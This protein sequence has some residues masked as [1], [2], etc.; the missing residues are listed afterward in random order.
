MRY[1]TF[2]II[3]IIILILASI[4]FYKPSLLEGFTGSQTNCPNILIQKDAKF[5]LYNT[6]IDE[7]PGVN[8]IVFDNLEQY[9]EF[10]D[11]QSKN[12]I[13]CPVLFLQKSYNTQ[14]AT[15]YKMRPS[16]TEPQ[17]GLPPIGA[18]TITKANDQRL[19]IPVTEYDIYD[20]SSPGFNYVMD[21]ISPSGSYLTQQKTLLIDG[22][23]NDMPYNTNSYPSYDPSSYYQGTITPL[24]QLDLLK[25]STGT[26]DNPMDTNWG[27]SNYTE[28]LL[29]QGTYKGN[30]VAIRIP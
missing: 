18:T 8:P 4:H 5:Y 30:E 15:E 26:S 25:E 12:G 23:R 10:L 16:V 28:K 17:G 3:I 2:I 14:G 19:D 20:T 27:G 24:D 13:K 22:G 21:K 11:W 9:T 7:V 6:K 1:L 29:A